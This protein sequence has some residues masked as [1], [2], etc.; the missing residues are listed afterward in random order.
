MKKER[1][2]TIA[3]RPKTK[4][5]FVPSEAPFSNDLGENGFAVK[6]IEKKRKKR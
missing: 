4:R 5:S 6:Q 2:F 3:L 1:S